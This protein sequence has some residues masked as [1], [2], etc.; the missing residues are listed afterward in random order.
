MGSGF[1]RSGGSP[2]RRAPQA[3]RQLFLLGLLLS[4]ALVLSAAQG[5]SEEPAQGHT[6]WDTGRESDELHEYGDDG[7]AHGGVWEHG[8]GIE[9]FFETSGDYD[10][11]GDEHYSQGESQ[12]E[13]DDGGPGRSAPSSAFRSAEEIAEEMELRRDEEERA[14]YAPPQRSPPRRQPRELSSPRE[15]AEDDDGIL[16]VDDLRGELPGV[17]T[18]V[19]GHLVSL[20]VQLLAVHLRVQHSITREMQRYDKGSSIFRMMRYVAV[21]CSWED[22]RSSHFP[23]SPDATDAVLW[24]RNLG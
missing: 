8:E 18:P 20:R 1:Q 12:W 9:E 21:Y 2:G 16:F 23:R 11:A 3:C 15:E 13:G 4:L 5:H 17:F 7:A 24:C 19:Q 14:G 22:G 6:A 10:P